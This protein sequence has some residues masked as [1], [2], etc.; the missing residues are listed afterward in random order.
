MTYI[1]QSPNSFVARKMEADLNTKDTLNSFLDA[2]PI[3]FV[4]MDILGP[5]SKTVQGNQCAV[6]ITDKYSKLTWAIPT[7]KTSS[8]HMTNVFLE[9]LEQ[10]IL[11][12]GIPSYFSW[13]MDSNLSVFLFFKYVPTLVLNA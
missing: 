12:I 2:E 8:N 4:A 11:V 13:T 5:L 7:S 3:D 1:K 10:W 9:L 6:V